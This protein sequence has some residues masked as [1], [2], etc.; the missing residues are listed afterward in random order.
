MFNAWHT[1]TKKEVLSRL[2][3]SEHGLSQKKARRRLKEG[4]QNVIPDAKRDPYWIIFLRQ[5][6]SP[7]IYIL[8]FATLIVFLLGEKIDGII[9]LS[10]ILFNSIVGAIQEGRAQNTLLALRRSVQT[11]ALILRDGKKIVVRDR[12]IVPGD[13][14]LLHEGDKVPADG[15]LFE[16]NH[17]LL[18]ESTLTGESLAV[19]KETRV[20]RKASLAIQKQSNMIFKG[21]NVVGGSGAAVVVATGLETEI[22]R[23][24]SEISKFDTEIPLHREL[25][26]LSRLIIA[27]V[28]LVVAILFALGISR[29]QVF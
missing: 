7:L 29:G 5:F 3:S 23:I 28:S 21:T 8:L 18:N 19:L 20:L 11:K 16:A 13:I 24:S 9:I 27:I 1:K 22:G 6:Q 17:L 2:Y 12:D 4:G 15:R 10:V 25:R 14:I 26:D